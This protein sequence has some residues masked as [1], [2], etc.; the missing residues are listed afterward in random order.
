ME[1]LT[2]TTLESSASPGPR[3][4]VRPEPWVMVLDFGAQ[5]VQ[6][7]A[8]RLREAGVFAEIHPWHLE[9]EAVRALAPAAIVISG[10]PASVNRADAPRLDPAILDLGLPILGICFGM[11]ASAHALGGKVKRGRSREY[12]RAAFRP[13]LACP[14]FEGLPST[15]RA[16]MSHADS[17]DELPAE[18]EP[19]GC[20]DSV[21]FAASWNP[22]RRLFARETNERGPL[23]PWPEWTAA[24]FAGSAARERSL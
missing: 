6:L 21:K 22:R 1:P 3:A 17:V 14:L 19:A 4:F 7:I 2:P 9:A 13:D 18:L 5:Y 20:T 10:S 12:G 23:S 11:Q 16:W 24:G 15:F 8:R